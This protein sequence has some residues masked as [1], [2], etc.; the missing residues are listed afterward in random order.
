MV[1]GDIFLQAGAVLEIVVGGAGGN[2]TGTGGAQ[3]GGGSFVN[4][5]YYADG[6]AD[7]HSG[8]GLVTIVFSSALPTITGPG[9]TTYANQGSTTD[10]PFAGVTIGDLNAGATD[11]LT[12]KLSV[13]NPTLSVGTAV[14]EVTF[15]N[16]VAGEYTLNGSAAG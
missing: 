4:P 5:S 9:G 7:A 11:T 12:I 2:G 16:P 10:P 8:D 15:T 3:G 14:A 1:S 13:A 6:T